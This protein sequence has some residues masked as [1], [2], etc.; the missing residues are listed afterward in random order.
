MNS[1]YW[2]AG[3]VV[4]ALVAIASAGFLGITGYI[5]SSGGGNPEV[6]VNIDDGKRV[7]TYRVVLTPRESAFDALKR[8]AVVDY[9]I[10]ATG[11]FI[12][13]INGVRQDENHYWLYFVNGELPEVGCDYY[14]PKDGD[15]ITFRYLSTEEAAKYF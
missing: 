8:V 5:V 1:R 9:K 4:I 13:E 3:V 6:Q 2:L 14:H 15:V 7:L 11:V 10:Y 12:T